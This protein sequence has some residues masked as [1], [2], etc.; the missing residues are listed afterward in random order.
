MGG[1][2]NGRRFTFEERRQI[3]DM[4]ASGKK[5]GE[6]AQALDA[7][8]SSIRNQLDALSGNRAGGIWSEDRVAVMLRMDAEG[9]SA[10]E[11]AVALNC[12]I[13]R[14][15]VIGKLHRSRLSRKAPAPVAHASPTRVRRAAPPPK[16]AN[17]SPLPPAP[18]IAP[19]EASQPVAAS[20]LLTFFELADH[21]A[22]KW[23][24]ADLYC[25]AP[26]ERRSSYCECHRALSV[27][28]GTYGERTALKAPRISALTGAF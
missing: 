24:I 6:I 3:A 15:G 16:P 19:P 1:N 11:I 18:Y 9:C 28:T 21:G 26:C 17:S 12:G 4:H 8:W 10:S 25:G 13:T 2:G 5:I 14:N 20:L 27:G 23:P 22:C 7:G